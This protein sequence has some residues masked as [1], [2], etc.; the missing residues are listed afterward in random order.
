MGCGIN[1]SVAPKIIKRV[2]LNRNDHISFIKNKKRN[3]DKSIAISEMSW[4]NVID[5]LNYNELKEAGKISQL[6]NA[7]VKKN[8]IL[9]KF[10]KKKKSIFKLSGAK[11]IDS[12]SILQNNTSFI[13]DYSTSSN[14]NRMAV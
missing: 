4:L 5:Y 13:S 6:F 8:S 11:S 10:F 14:E 3:V 12:F 7:L 1:K 9:I 2:K